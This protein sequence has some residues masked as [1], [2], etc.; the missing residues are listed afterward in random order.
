MDKTLHDLGGILLSGLPTF[1]LVLILAFFVKT[2]YVTPLKKVL[3]ERHRLTEGAKKAAED[4]LQNAESKIAE[5]EE[6]LS[7]A[8]DGIYQDQAEFLRK[9]HDEQA[10]QI[11]SVRAESDQRIATAKQAL[12]AEADSARQ[13]LEAQSEA[14]AGQI[15]DSILRPEVSVG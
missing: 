1:F 10:E 8:R 9:V 6:A 4:S 11:R 14:L 5:Y 2:L 13:S 7:R 12:A 15:A 3:A